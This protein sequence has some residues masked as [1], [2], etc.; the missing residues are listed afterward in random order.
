MEKSS[1]EWVKKNGGGIFELHSYAVPDDF[2][3]AEVRNQ[4]LKE[5]DEYFP[6]IKGYKVRYE[7]LQVKDDF[8]AFHTNLFKTRPKVKTE[9]E[10]LFL[11][12]DWVRLES[13]AML[14]EAATTSAMVASNSIFRN[15]GLKEEPVL[16][17]PL[18]GLLQ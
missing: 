17:V 4:F 8:T 2:P 10:N 3:E 1:E 14:M 15:E 13:P 7:H 11:A 16:S 5:F 6:E 12:G 18:K 9:V